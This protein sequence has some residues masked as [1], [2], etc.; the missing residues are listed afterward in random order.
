MLGQLADALDRGA[1]L[2]A[3]IDA[4]GPA[5]PGHLRGLVRAGARTGRTAEFLGRLAGFTQIGRSIHRRLWLRLAYPLMALGLALVVVGFVMTEVVGVLCRFVADFGMQL[6]PLSVALIKISAPLESN[7]R[8]MVLWFAA[9][10]GLAAL[11]FYLIGP[12]GRRS[13]TGWLPLIGP[14]GRWTSLA[15]FFRL[16]ALQ[17]ESELPLAEAVVAA[18]DGTPDLRLRRAARAVADQLAHGSSLS[19]AMESRSAFPSGSPSI[20]A[21]GEQHRSTQQALEMLGML[22]EA[23]AEAQATFAGT[24]ISVLTVFLIILLIGFVIVGVFAPMIRLISLLSG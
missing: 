22:Y 8:W 18:G 4:Q 21:W 24:V 16:L 5:L 19:K 12:A 2:E 1:S 20:V 13:L 17:V 10:A 3:A 14:V 7:G 9:T 15:E 11:L 23:R 6:Q